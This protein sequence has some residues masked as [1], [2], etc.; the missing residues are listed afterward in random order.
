MTHK[1]KKG[2]RV[3]FAKDRLP[4]FGFYREKV[5]H[6]CTYTVGAI[7]QHQYEE[8]WVI[9]E[10]FGPNDGLMPNRFELVCEAPEEIPM[11]TC[12]TLDLTKPVQLS[13]GRKA[14]IIATDRKRTLSDGCDYPIVALVKNFYLNDEEVIIFTREGR[15]AKRYDGVTLVNVPEPIEEI[16]YLKAPENPHGLPYV[17]SSKHGSGRNIASSKVTFERG[18]FA[19]AC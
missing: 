15:S 16:V 14:R 9:L 12:S 4:D 5:S 18:K 3:R 7:S 8:G 13:D 10:G 6:N 11:D 1:F 2:D 19:D 17:S